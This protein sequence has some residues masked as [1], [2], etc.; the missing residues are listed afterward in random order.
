M[1][2]TPAA[3]LHGATT[4]ELQQLADKDIDHN[5]CRIQLSRRPH[6]TPLVPWT[7]TALQ[8]C[9]DHRKALCSNDTYLLIAMRTK[10]IR[11]VGYDN[12]SLGAVG[13]WFGRGSCG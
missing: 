3:L 9:L 6:P 10:A 1:S 8:R 5:H 12:N 4:Q 13:I 7:W 2:D 11:S